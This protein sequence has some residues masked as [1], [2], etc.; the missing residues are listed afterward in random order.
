MFPELKGLCFRHKA[1]KL[2][3]EQ[4]VLNCEQV[5]SNLPKVKVVRITNLHGEKESKREDQFSFDELLKKSPLRSK[6]ILTLFENLVE[7]FTLP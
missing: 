1:L 5:I 7:V 3:L 4:R 2:E 6:E